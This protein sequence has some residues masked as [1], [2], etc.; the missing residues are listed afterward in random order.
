[1]RK[2]ENGEDKVSTYCTDP[3]ML[4]PN[5][6]ALATTCHRTIFLSGQNYTDDTTAGVSGDLWT[7]KGKRAYQFPP[8]LLKEA[9]IHRTN[10]IETSPDGKALYL[11]SAKNVGGAVVANQIF[12][13][14]LQAGRKLVEE[15]PTLFYD[16]TGDGAATDVD[17][18][19]TDTDGNLFVTR[20]GEGKIFK[21]SPAG[22]L[23]LVI[24]LPGMGGPS[25]L[26]FGGPDGKTLFA[27]GRCAEDNT[28]GCAASVQT[29]STGKAFAR[30]Q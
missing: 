26:E 15:A 5:D 16:F 8:E 25:N 20:N 14:R 21:I 17:G 23:L 28:V 30:L 4:Q 13:F 11:S 24:E 18:M 1:M 2:Q 9:D 6:L 10:G 7:C 3:G 19:R 27:I 29:E 12:K 22:Q